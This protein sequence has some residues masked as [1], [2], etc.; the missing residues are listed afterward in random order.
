MTTLGMVPARPIP[1]TARRGV[2][3]RLKHG[4]EVN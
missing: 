3:I 2:Q 1:S 4:N